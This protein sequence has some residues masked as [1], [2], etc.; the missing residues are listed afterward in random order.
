MNPDRQSKEQDLQAWEE[1]LKEREVNVRMRELESE[2]DASTPGKLKAKRKAAAVRPWYKCLPKIVRFGLLILG[3]IV[4]VR[5]AAWLAG[6]LLF[7]GI[8]WIGYKLFIERD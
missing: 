7:L 4:A 3:A 2:I 5:V 1:T 6:L 8:I